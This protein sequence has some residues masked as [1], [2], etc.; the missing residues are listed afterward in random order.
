MILSPMA[1]IVDNR[2]SHMFAWEI[3]RIF[4]YFELNDEPIEAESV[5]VKLRVSNQF[6][7]E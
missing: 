2:S 6:E 4:I 7:N 3:A 5:L 1:L